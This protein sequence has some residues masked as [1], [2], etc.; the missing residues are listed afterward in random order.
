MLHRSVV[1]V[2]LF[3]T[4]ALPL[5]LLAQAGGSGLSF[6]KIGADARAMAMGDVGVVTS[7]LGAAM[8]YNPALLSDD[9]DASITI[10]HNEWV[11]DLSTE[12]LGVAV[13]FSSWTLGIHM[14]LTSVEGIEIRDRPGEAQGTF[15]SRNFAGGLS[16]AFALTDGVD[17]GITAKYVMEK[18]YTDAAD[19]YAF[20]FG[21]S[22]D[23]FEGGDLHG[24]RFGLALANLGS[25]SELRYAATTLP[26]LLR[27]GAS[28]DIPVPSLKSTLVV[29]GG[30]MSV[31]EDEATHAAVGAE[32]NYVNSVYFRAGYQSGYEIKNVSF[33]AGFAYTTLRFD[34]AFTPFTESFGAA[35]TIALSIRL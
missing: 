1:V 6:L 34:Y 4:L 30:V 15:D 8:Y 23:P 16:M 22:I 5:Q 24:L 21:A 12:F 9:E 32:F 19:G 2:F 18:I 7:D 13:P 31:F 11:Q 29:I 14:G 10:M 35:H 27:A 28:Y 25:M 3:T 26:T 20:D 33:G 17:L